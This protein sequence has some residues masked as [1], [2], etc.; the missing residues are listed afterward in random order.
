MRKADHSE[1]AAQAAIYIAEG[2]TDWSAARRRLAEEKRI[3]SGSLL[4]SDEEIE[5]ALREHF[6]IF[7]AKGHAERLL[8][9]RKIALRVMME[10]SEYS[11]K[12]I[13]GVLNGCADRYSDIFLTVETDDAKSLEIDLMDRG[14]DL[15]VLPNESNL[16]GE[17]VEEIVFEAPLPKN[18]FFAQN[19]ITVWVRVRV[20]EGRALIK[21]KARRTPD[22]WQIE[23]ET[24]RSADIQLLQKIIRLTDPH[25]QNFV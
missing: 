25:F 4:P 22:P 16:K 15:E 18:S 20:F 21:N 3:S 5:S 11:P 2:E 8:E 10:L 7:D 1:L 9:L 24:A 13:R 23:E 17:P 6:A 14:I 19:D 12:L